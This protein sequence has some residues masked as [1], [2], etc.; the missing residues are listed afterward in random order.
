MIKDVLKKLKQNGLYVQNIPENEQTQEMKLAAVKQ[1]GYAL[2]HIKQQNFDVC[3]EAINTN[4]LA[5]KFV[6]KEQLTPEEYEELVNCAV[7]KNKS[8]QKLLK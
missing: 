4:A 3:F 1:I 7:K 8:V 5:L 6:L 2:Q